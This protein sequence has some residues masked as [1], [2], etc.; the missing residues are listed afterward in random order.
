MNGAPEIW[1]DQESGD[2]KIDA[3]GGLKNQ[4]AKGARSGG[5]NP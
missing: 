5:F 2:P 3:D 1:V 4:E